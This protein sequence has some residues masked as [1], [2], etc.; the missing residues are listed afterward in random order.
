V[1]WNATIR[2]CDPTAWSDCE[3]ECLDSIIYQCTAHSDLHLP[4]WMSITGAIVYDQDYS[5]NLVGY[6]KVEPIS[7]SGRMQSWLDVDGSACQ[8][9]WGT[10]I[11]GSNVDAGDW[12]AA[13]VAIRF[14]RR[15]P[16][17]PPVLPR[18]GARAHAPPSSSA[19][20]N[21]RRWKIDDA[22]E[23]VAGGLFY[24]CPAEDRLLTSMVLGGVPRFAGK[25]RHRRASV[26]VRMG[27]R[28]VGGNRLDDLR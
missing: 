1:F 21:L 24:C 28:F 22:C 18:R 5:S 2:G 10:T 8:K 3:D 23:L 27:R 13:R 20:P 16:A 11:L 17:P 19:T 7:I 6:N 14:P 9:A 4:E 25:R 26:G 12:R 15:P